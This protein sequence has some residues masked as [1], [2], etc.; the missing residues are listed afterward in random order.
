[1]MHKDVIPTL[2]FCSFN[3]Q[4]FHSPLFIVKLKIFYSTI[5]SIF[6]TQYVDRKPFLSSILQLCRML[7]IRGTGFCVKQASFHFQWFT[8]QMLPTQEVSF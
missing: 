6:R 1:M 5:A 8:Y 4:T 7:N 2:D 3:G